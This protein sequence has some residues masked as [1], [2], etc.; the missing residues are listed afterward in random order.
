M[1]LDPHRVALLAAALL[2][3]LPGGFSCCFGGDGF[4]GGIIGLPGESFKNLKVSGTLSSRPGRQSLRIRY[5]AS[6]LLRATARRPGRT[7]GGNYDGEVLIRNG[8]DKSKVGVRITRRVIYAGI[9][10]KI[11]LK[12]PLRMK[13]KGRQK[14]RGRVVGTA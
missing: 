10:G 2:L 8:R 7:V 14:I 3:L 11:K 13:Q 12:R 9:P 4:G 5:P 1:S 6:V